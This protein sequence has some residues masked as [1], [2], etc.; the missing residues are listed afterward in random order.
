[1]RNFLKN[2]FA[3]LPLLKSLSPKTL[4]FQGVQVVEF[5]KILY[6][7][8]ENVNLKD[9]NLEETLFERACDEL[10]VEK[11]FDYG[12]SYVLNDDKAFVFLALDEVLDEKCEF[13]F[14]EPLLWQG[15]NKADTLK[16]AQIPTL[17]AVLVL[18]KAYG[19]AVFYED[20]RLLALKNLPLFSLDYLQSKDETALQGF[21]AERICPVLTTLCKNHKSQ[22]LIFVGDE[23]NFGDFLASK[24]EIS[25][26]DLN[27]F[28]QKSHLKPLEWARFLQSKIQG[29]TSNF[30]RHKIKSDFSKRLMA[31]FVA[32][33]LLGFCFVG[34]EFLL[35]RH[36]LKSSFESGLQMPKF[37]TLQKQNSAN[38]LKIEQ[39]KEIFSYI[40]KELKPTPLLDTLKP[41]FNLL[42][43][44]QIELESVEFSSGEIKILIPHS[45]TSTNFIKSL[46]ANAFFTLKRKE[47][48]GELYELI[49]EKK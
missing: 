9:E 40:A 22:M 41:L 12:A 15:L 11:R 13:S 33:F 45:E 21:L 32:C 36:A 43:E 39:K 20:N 38:A 34:A 17:Y 25:S 23:L 35:K 4:N 14:A 26:L 1:M 19:Y 31:G 8:L 24:L 10:G 5:D 6:A 18:Q 46:Y 2:G 28:T 27:K 16:K 37:S 49:L 47:L 44:S 3:S 30:L 29:K 42:Y 48:A 7:E